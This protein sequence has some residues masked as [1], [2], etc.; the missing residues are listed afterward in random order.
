M[1]RLAR[2]I[3]PV[4]ALRHPNLVGLHAADRTD[5]HCWIAMEL[6]EGENLTQ[7]LQRVGLAG[8]L[9]WQHALRIALHIGRALKLL[10]E[11]K[12]IHRNVLP[13]NILINASDKLAKL[14][15]L[16]QARTLEASMAEPAPAI[17]AVM[18]DLAYMPPER[19]RGDVHGDARS[20]IYSL[21]ATIHTLLT[22]R[23]PFEGKTTPE[24][25]A[26]VLQAEPAR[27]RELQLSLPEAFERA[28]LKMMAKRPE[29]R[30]QTAADLLVDLERS[31]SVPASFVGAPGGS[32][33]AADGRILV[34]CSCG[35][36]L[37]AR[38]KYSGTRV[39][40]PACGDLLLLPGK[41][42]PEPPAS[43]PARREETTA[44]SP[45]RLLPRLLT[46]LLV[47]LLVA[48]AAV[49]LVGLLSTPST[50][51]TPTEQSPDKKDPSAKPDTATPPTGSDSPG[52]N[53]P[54]PR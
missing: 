53:E 22:G 11:H 47:V 19:V 10:H 5:S 1:Q 54:T 24:T 28:V 31:T 8:M 26:R 42:P 30:Y 41:A 52:R 49:Y 21:G 29:D 13:R 45:P 32:P 15:A 9:D 34:T 48:G 40:C 3:K 20:D 35:Q 37:Q 25:I 12:I 6:V 27:P 51:P 46:Y 23:P 33:Q 16:E 39:R 44:K 38:Q 14:G 36:T 4:L 7:L 18:R 17:E 2:A 43:K 50:P